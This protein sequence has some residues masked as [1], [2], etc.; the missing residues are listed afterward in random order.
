MQWDAGTLQDL[1]ILHAFSRFLS[2]CYFSYLD[3]FLCVDSFFGVKS[4]LMWLLSSIRISYCFVAVFVL[5]FTLLWI[6]SIHSQVAIVWSVSQSLSISLSTSQTRTIDLSSFLL[7]QIISSFF[8]QYTC[9]SNPP[10]YI[11]ND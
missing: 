1:C 4:S 8:Q 5:L 10:T 9:P 6:S 7:L 2:S 11:A 3:G